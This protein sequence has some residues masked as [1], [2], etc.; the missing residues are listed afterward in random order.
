MRKRWKKQKTDRAGG[1]RLLPI[2]PLRPAE[3]Q[4][5]TV[6]IYGAASQRASVYR[7]ER[8]NRV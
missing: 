1:G 8:Q 7:R 5:I 3:S 4:H 2:R 6:A